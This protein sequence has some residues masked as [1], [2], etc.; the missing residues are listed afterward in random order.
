[1][2][3]ALISTRFNINRKY[4]TTIFYTRFCFVIVKHY[5]KYTELN[6]QTTAVYAVAN[7]VANTNVLATA[8]ATA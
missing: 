4:G 3:G 2:I 6:L 5:F 8:L 7:A 1:M